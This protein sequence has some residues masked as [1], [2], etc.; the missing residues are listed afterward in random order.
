MRRTGLLLS[1]L[2]LCGSSV[3]LAADR[4]T[5]RDVK[6]LVARI[7][8]G[9]DRFDDALDGKLKH[10]IVRGPAGEVNVGDYLNDFQENIDRLEE[11]LKP[12]YAASAEAGALLRQASA[13]HRFFRQQPAGTR[14]ESE[15]NRLETDLK[16]LAIAYGADFPLAENA[17]VRRIGDRE[18][19]AAIGQVASTADRLKKSLDNELKKDAAMDK[20]ARQAVVGEADQLSKDAKVLRDRVKDGKPSTGEAER[21]LAGATKLQTFIDSHRVPASAA[22]WTSAGQPLQTLT[23]AYRVPSPVRK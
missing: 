3:V 2:T 20:P 5:D 18:L 1:I 4:L 6:A 7:E 8:Q 19:A 9:R 21:V 23:S 17:T 15:W 11:R 14:G 16:A 10:S 22:A 12:D 13:I